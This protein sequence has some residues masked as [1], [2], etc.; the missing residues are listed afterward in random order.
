MISMRCWGERPRRL[1][2]GDLV[3]GQQ[4]GVDQM[5]ERLEDWCGARRPA[6][7]RPR[8]YRAAVSPTR[9]ASPSRIS[10]AN[11]PRAA[12]LDASISP[13]GFPGP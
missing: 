10:S 6:P 11:T 5:I 4:A 2:R 7:C 3:G 1:R 8:L 12:L 13:R 9:P